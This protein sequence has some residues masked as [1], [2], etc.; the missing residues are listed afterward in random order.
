VREIRGNAGLS[1]KVNANRQFSLTDT[2]GITENIYRRQLGCVR[3]KSVRWPMTEC[4][5]LRD[6]MLA[7]VSTPRFT[8][9]G[10]LL[11]SC[12]ASRGVAIELRNT[13]GKRDVVRQVSF[14]QPMTSPQMEFEAP[15]LGEE[16]Y[17]DESVEPCTSCGEPG[18][19]LDC[20]VPNTK[21]ANFEYLLWWRKGMDLPALA[22]TTSSNNL[23]DLRLGLGTTTTLFGDD[24]V[25]NEARPGGRVSLGMW[26]DDCENCGVEGRFYSLGR[27]SINFNAASDGTTPL[28]RPFTNTIP[29]PDDPTSRTLA[30]A[31]FN[32]DGS[33]D[34]TGESDL[35][36]GDVLYR[37]VGCTYDNSRIYLL[38]GYQYARLDEHLLIRDS[39]NIT[40][41]NNTQSITDRFA[42]R[43]EFHAG[44]IGFAYECLY[45]CWQLDLLAKVGFGNMKQTV[46]IAGTTVNNGVP[47][48]PPI[49]LL[50]IDNQGVFTQDKFSVSPEI[51]ATASYSLNECIQLSFG[52]SFI[53]WSSVAQA[54]SHIPANLNVPAPF[55]FN[56]TSYWVHGL[57]AGVEF[58]F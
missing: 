56:D 44:E 21:W 20:L 17:Y 8:L 15:S 53:Y 46:D 7:M 47:V 4:F 24:T 10:M 43:N 6:G 42:T 34:V 55:A 41:T 1:R 50:A 27:Q 35:L 31:G 40:A 32:S 23:N 36:G 58:R 45:D 48:N 49:G 57:N 5:E 3:T 13:V 22:I 37:M 52:Y 29:N 30:F 18:C 54:G 38:A 28:G 16:I 33:I 26:L 12:V 19:F 2:I 25:G 51:N 39:T 9:L 14:M 11:I